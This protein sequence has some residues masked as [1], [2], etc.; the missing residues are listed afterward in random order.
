MDN[1]ADR[2]R[3]N[4]NMKAE[5]ISLCK[6]GWD[7]RFILSH[8]KP[9][10]FWLNRETVRDIIK[11]AGMNGSKKEAGSARNELPIYR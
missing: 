3:A 11:N 5:I 4:E 10:Y 2:T 8:L 7:V 9:K 6:S 1:S